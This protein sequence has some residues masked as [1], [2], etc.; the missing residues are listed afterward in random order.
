MNDRTDEIRST[1]YPALKEDQIEVLGRYGETR[2]TTDGQVLFKAGD[3]S[4]D[5]LVVLG[6]VVEVVDDFAGKARAIGVF[7]AGSFLGDLHML[8]GQGYLSAVVREGGKLLA[9]PREKLKQVVNEESDLSDIIL[10]TFLVR[11]S[12]LMRIGVGL[13]IVGSRHSSAATRLRELAGRNRLPHVWIELEK[14]PEAEA[15]LRRCGAKPSE[16]PVTI[17]QGK[18]LLKNPTNSEL[19]RT[20]GLKVD[21]PWD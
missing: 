6:G 5:F 7:R 15:L 14:D 11:R 9:I 8:T 2:V 3:A 20:M 13:R 1:L 21:V 16:T 18:V 19:A 12:H 10:K 4:N 17:W